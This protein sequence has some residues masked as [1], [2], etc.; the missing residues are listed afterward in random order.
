MNEQMG[1]IRPVTQRELPNGQAV[2]YEVTP[3]GDVEISTRFRELPD[4]GLIEILNETRVPFTEGA[5]GFGLFSADGE[6]MS[7]WTLLPTHA[8]EELRLEPG[9]G[10]RASTAQLDLSQLQTAAAAAG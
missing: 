5:D 6:L 3:I 10:F 8:G 2:R 7:W 9:W 1:T 4:A